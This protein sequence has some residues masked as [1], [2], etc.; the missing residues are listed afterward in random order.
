MPDTPELIDK[1]VDELGQFV[2]R[3]RHDGIREEVIHF[4]LYQA[5]R[6]SEMKIIAKG[7][8]SSDSAESP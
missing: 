8:L 6:D 4:I 5:A 1:Y 3:M 2:T 7:E